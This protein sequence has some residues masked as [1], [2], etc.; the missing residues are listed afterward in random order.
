MVIYGLSKYVF[1]EQWPWLIASIIIV[2]P[3]SALKAYFKEREQ[4]FYV[5]ETRMLGDMITNIQEGKKITVGVD[6][7]RLY[8]IP[9]Y[10]Y[11][12][13]QHTGEPDLRNW[14]VGNLIYCD[15]KSQST[16]FHAEFSELANVQFYAR[17]KAFLHIKQQYP[18]TILENAVLTFLRQP[19]IAIATKE[20]LLKSMGYMAEL[21]K[22][23]EQIKLL[24]TDDIMAMAEKGFTMTGK[25]EIAPKTPKK[26]DKSEGDDSGD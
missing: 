21:D 2:C 10:L 4:D 22:H 24:D 18:K 8:R 19:Q 26:V 20:L 17:K 3:I 5:L 13:Y 14:K 25:K 9:K 15:Y 16:L 1:P 11:E 7:Q 12:Q 6:G 23:Y